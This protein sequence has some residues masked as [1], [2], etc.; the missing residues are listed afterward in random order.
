MLIIVQSAKLGN[1][2]QGILGDGFGMDDLIA[3]AGE[4]GI[5][6][7]VPFLAVLGVV[8]VVIQLDDGLDPEVL[9]GDQEVHVLG[10][11]FHEETSVV[12]LSPSGFN[13]VQDVI[14]G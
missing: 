14:G 3:H 7:L 8:A 6:E 1:I 10:L 12:P 11:H 13:D 4:D 5:H 2:L 9:V